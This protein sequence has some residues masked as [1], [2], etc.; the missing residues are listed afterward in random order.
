MLASGWDAYTLAFA[1]YYVSA[2]LDEPLNAM[3]IVNTAP[4]PVS[5]SWLFGIIC[6]IFGSENVQE[7]PGHTQNT[8]RGAIL[9]LGW[10]VIGTVFLHRILIA[11]LYH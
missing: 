7:M 9:E 6:S 2:V 10:F 4:L 11:V 3:F 5:G 1:E 8:G